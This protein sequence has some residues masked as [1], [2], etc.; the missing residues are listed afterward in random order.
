[1]KQAI[2]NFPKQFEFEPKIE[3]ADV[4]KK[5]NKFLICGMGGSNLAADL[6]KIW[7]PSLDILTHKDYGLPVLSDLQDRL[8]ILSSYSGNT[9]EVIDAWKQVKTHG[10]SAAVLTTGGKLL[11]LAK[12]ASLPY[13][14]MP[15]TGIQPRSALGLNIRGL[16][17]I[18]GLEVALD[19]SAELVKKLNVSAAETA[20]TDLASRLKDFVPIIY[21]SRRNIGIAYN[22][23]IKLNE[24]GKIPSFYNVIPEMNHNEMTG[25][26]VSDTTRHLSEKFYFIILR[27][28]EDYPHIQK[29]MEVLENVYKDR[30]LKVEVITMEGDAAFYKIFTSLLMADWTA[31]GIAEHYG[32]EAEQVPMVEEFKQMI[33]G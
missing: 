4:L 5:T 10:A 12:E 19:K 2:N 33:G 9:E 13:V 15:N 24:T 20:G 16:M 6:L 29:R 25:L 30:K 3:N 23:K 26:D 7:D 18:M 8:V 14:V 17:K 32:L 31:L 27:D 22:W 1:M 28:P 11:D 21:T